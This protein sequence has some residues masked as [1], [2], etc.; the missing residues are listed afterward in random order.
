M[1]YTSEHM[2]LQIF[3]LHRLF[4]IKWAQKTLEKENTQR[5]EHNKVQGL[6][7]SVGG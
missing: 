2:Y 1:E 5:K 4:D 6:V 7:V 3:Y